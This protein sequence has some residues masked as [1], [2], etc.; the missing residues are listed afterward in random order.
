MTVNSIDIS[1]FS[2][3]Y[4]PDSGY[5]DAHIEEFFQDYTEFLAQIKPGRK[6]VIGR[7]VNTTLGIAEKHSDKVMLGK[8]GIKSRRSNSLEHE[9]KK[10]NVKS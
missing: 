5:T 6:I 2:L 10:R 3:Y 7:D 1:N 4:N 9:L 8:F